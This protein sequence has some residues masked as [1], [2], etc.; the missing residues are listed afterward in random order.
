M[1]RMSRPL[2]SLWPTWTPSASHC[3]AISTLSFTTKGTRYVL[4][5]AFSFS[6][7]SSKRSS[8]RSFS[9]ICRK[10]APFCSTDSATDTRLSPSFS[11]IRSVTA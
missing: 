3:R 5:R 4:H 8:S 9:R 6:D 1:A 7:S 10:V 11:H 2:M